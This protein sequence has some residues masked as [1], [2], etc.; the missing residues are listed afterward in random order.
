VILRGQSKTI[1]DVRTIS[2]M[3]IFLYVELPSNLF[4]N[5]TDISQ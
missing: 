1:P 4:S 5:S 3:C 2:A